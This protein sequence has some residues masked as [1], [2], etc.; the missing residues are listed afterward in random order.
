MGFGWSYGVRDL[1]K[2][3]GEEL[4]CDDIRK[5]DEDQIMEVFNA[6]LRFRAMEVTE[7]FH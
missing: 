5:A 6:T 1:A 2:A 7:K 4:V 3:R